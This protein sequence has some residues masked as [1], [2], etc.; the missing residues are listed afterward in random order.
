MPIIQF[1]HRGRRPSGL[2]RVNWD[3]DCRVRMAYKRASVSVRHAPEFQMKPLPCYSLPH[4]TRTTPEVRPKN[5]SSIY[6]SI[7]LSI[8]PSVCL[9]VRLSI[10]PSIY[11]CIY[12]WVFFSIYPST[13][14][15]FSPDNF[16]DSLTHWWSWALLEKLPIA[17]PLK[18]LSQ[19]FMEPEG[20]LRCSQEP[21]TG[22]YSE[23]DQSNSYHPNLSL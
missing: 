6:L 22:P 3:R 1:V 15:L 11:L 8:Y 16:I 17:Q 2:H 23:P 9:S 5:P 19:H 20:S 10:Y 21:S 4:F 13:I 14:H 18:K 12:L 7:Y